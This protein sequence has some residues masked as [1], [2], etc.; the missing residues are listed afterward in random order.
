MSC[1]AGYATKWQM[2]WWTRQCKFLFPDLSFP[3]F[4]VIARWSV[5]VW[6]GLRR[7]PQDVLFFSS[8]ELMFCSNAQ[9]IIR[10][11]FI[12]IY[13]RFIWSI[14][15]SSF[16]LHLGAQFGRVGVSPVQAVL[17]AP[18]EVQTLELGG[19]LAQLEDFVTFHDFSRFS[20]WPKNSTQ[21]HNSNNTLSRRISWKCGKVGFSDLKLETKLS[22]E[23]RKSKCKGRYFW[24]ARD[25]QVFFKSFFSLFWW[26]FGTPK[27]DRSM[28][29]ARN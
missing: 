19:S 3:K 1:L 25:K 16:H 22:M 29:V 28:Q 4:L 26:Y 6:A 13:A 24:P 14:G 21:N 15:I 18:S 7:N 17:D 11:C 5:A 23:I 27:L 2:T 8:Y 12:D 10:F 20:K 9:R